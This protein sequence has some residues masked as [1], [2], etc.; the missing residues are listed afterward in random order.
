TAAVA[1]P[2]SA[3]QAIRQARSR[4]R[5]PG[6]GGAP[7]LCCPW[8]ELKGSDPAFRAGLA[9]ILDERVVVVAMDRYADGA[10]SARPGPAAYRLGRRADGARPRPR[11]P[12][13]P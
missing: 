3:R 9:R 13:P 2:S 6:R 4:A 7:A 10:G 1:L 12:P 11:P 8:V 5:P